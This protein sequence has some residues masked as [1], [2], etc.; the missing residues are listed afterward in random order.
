MPLGI[1]TSLK[2][3]NSLKFN[4]SATRRGRK[5]SEN[6]NNNKK[7]FLKRLFLKIEYLGKARCSLWAKEG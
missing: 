4:K 3:A 7:P 1:F 5:R 6:K 2:D